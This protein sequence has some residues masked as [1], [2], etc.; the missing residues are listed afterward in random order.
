MWN[1][2]FN[3]GSSTFA[4]TMKFTDFKYVTPD[5]HSSQIT[6]VKLKD[7]EGQKLKSWTKSQ[8]SVDIDWKNLSPDRTR[9]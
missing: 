5:P 7:S 1:Y 2:N 6:A 8:D 9:W 4:S 3:K